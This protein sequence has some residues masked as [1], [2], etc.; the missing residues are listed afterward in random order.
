VTFIEQMPPDDAYDARS[1]LLTT[2][3]G[4]L[5][6]FTYLIILLE[7]GKI[8]QALTEIEQYRT[9]LLDRDE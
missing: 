1:Q 9:I 8:R 5:E 2:T 4:L 6:V 7:E 3:G